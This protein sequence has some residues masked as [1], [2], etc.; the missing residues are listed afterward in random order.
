MTQVADSVQSRKMNKAACLSKET[1]Q[2]LNIHSSAMVD[3]WSSPQLDMRK[4]CHHPKK[5]SA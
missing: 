4:A 5:K 3:L 1:S 2:P